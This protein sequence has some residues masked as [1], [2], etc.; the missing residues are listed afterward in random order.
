MGKAS[1]SAFLVTVMI[2]LS[3][4]APSSAGS[5]TLF[6]PVN[7]VST[8]GISVTI[9]GLDFGTTSYTPTVDLG[10]GT[11]CATTSWTS[12]STVNCLPQY[13]QYGTGSAIKPYFRG[14]STYTSVTDYFTFDAPAVSYALSPTSGKTPNGPQSGDGSVTIS[15]LNF[16]AVDATA[17]VSL[18]ANCK[19]TSWTSMTTLSCMTGK[20]SAPAYL[21]ETV[22]ITGHTGTFQSGLYSFDAPAL[23]YHKNYNSCTSGGAIL[24]VMGLNFGP[25]DYTPTAHI[26]GEL[27]F[28][29][30]IC[31]TTSWSTD[32][33]V[34]CAAPASFGRKQFP[35]LTISGVVG[36]RPGGHFSYDKPVP[37]HAT[38]G[39]APPLAT[40]AYVTIFGLNFA[41]VD[42]T[43]TAFINNNANLVG[44]YDVCTTTSWSS[45]TAVTCMPNERGADS[46]R[47]VAVGGLGQ[48]GTGGAF[49]YDGPIITSNFEYNQPSSGGTTVTISGLN[50]GYVD[51]TPESYVG[52]SYCQTT[53]WSSATTVQCQMPT[54]GAGTNAIAMG[55]I[56]NVNNKYFG[57]L[58]SAFTFDAPTVSFGTP[59][60]NFANMPVTGGLTLSVSGFNFGKAD[61]SSTGSIGLTTCATLSW[62]SATSIDCVTPVGAGMKKKL[63]VTVG[64]VVGTLASRFSF[65]APSVTYSYPINGPSQTG[66]MLTLDG[67]NYASANLSPSARLGGT[68]CASTQWIST[69][70]IK[71]VVTS[72]FKG[73]HLSAIT[74]EGIVGTRAGRFTFDAPVPT[75][76]KAANTPTTGGTS[77]TMLGMSFGS[78]DFSATAAI[79]PF[80]CKTTSWTTSSSITCL[81]SAG[82]AGTEPVAYGVAKAMVIT[83]GAIVGTRTSKFT[84]DS[85]AITSTG[86]NLPTTNGATL[87]VFGLNFGYGSTTPTTFLG[88]DSTACSTTSWTTVSTVRCASAGGSGPGA[89]VQTAM[90]A[91]IIGTGLAQFTFDAPTDRKSVV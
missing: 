55:R 51:A 29:K 81:S 88:D 22:T 7:A 54:A 65:D 40:S 85:P 57:T 16:A 5:I 82:T 74:V 49:T 89:G 72:G 26:G 50:F 24:T 27:S 10:S 39:N 44:L 36:T 73:N 87:T 53:S 41:P 18:R 60:P 19:T 37:T 35:A 32:T 2:G 58:L 12:V 46:M 68:A 1:A 78:Y 59:G 80:D 86:T 33:A 48:S 30:T 70:Q 76:L 91:S 84:Y 28:S 56:F 13:S 21:A 11:S 17:T 20:V 3:L 66:Y 69:T 9:S 8:G 52:L 6:N 43:A 77:V 42:A 79:D 62:K 38:P 67:Q 25:V 14:Q 71:C 63:T 83:V 45:G 64:A 90:L 4:V 75:H 34:R 15:G 47:S 23:S 61:F 31:M